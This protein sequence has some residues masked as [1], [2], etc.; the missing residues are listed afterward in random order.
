MIRSIVADQP[1][2]D[3]T[4]EKNKKEIKKILKENNY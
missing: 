4:K 1:Y 3:V 2:C